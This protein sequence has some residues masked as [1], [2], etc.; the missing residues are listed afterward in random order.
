MQSFDHRQTS[1]TIIVNQAVDGQHKRSN[2]LA[3]AVGERQQ[4]SERWPPRRHQS[5][6]SKKLTENL[7]IERISFTAA[8][9]LLAISIF[10]ITVVPT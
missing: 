3:P 7:R 5:S 1:R 2:R 8:I 6:H 9:P 10:E 4:L